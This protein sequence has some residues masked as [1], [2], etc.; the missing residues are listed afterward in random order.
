MRF[1]KIKNRTSR[2][3]TSRR[4]MRR[5][6]VED[7]PQHLPLRELEQHFRALDQPETSA[8]RLHLP[9]MAIV[10]CLPLR[11]QPAEIIRVQP[12]R[13]G[14]IP[15]SRDFRDL[16]RPRSNRRWSHLRR[17]L[18]DRNPA[19]ALRPRFHKSLVRPDPLGDP[20][21]RRPRGLAELKAQFPRQRTQPT[22]LSHV[23]HQRFRPCHQSLAI[24]HRS[25]REG[26]GQVAD[27]MGLRGH[28]KNVRMRRSPAPQRVLSG[29][30]LFT[31][32]RDHALAS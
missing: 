3:E 25:R 29:A 8:L 13:V 4:L 9:A 16:P 26:G 11:N 5:D 7:F 10:I 20:P 14:Q 24:R 1:H 30:G 28:R 2:S 21:H 6:G 15:Q 31:R 27:L 17:D 12:Q 22:C 19:S 32:K 23:T 18:A